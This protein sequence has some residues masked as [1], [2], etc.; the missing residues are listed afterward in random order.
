MKKNTTQK[1]SIKNELV[2]ANSHINI[3]LY[4]I[5]REL[6]DEDFKKLKK[7]ASYLVKT[8]NLIDREL[9]SYRKRKVN[10]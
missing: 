2:D 4:T 6:P 10:L 3:L 8:S 7:L 9:L 1:V 5:V